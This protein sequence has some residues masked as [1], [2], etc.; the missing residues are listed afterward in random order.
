MHRSDVILRNFRSPYFVL[1]FT[2]EN[3]KSHMGK[4]KVTGTNSCHR[5]KHV[6]RRNYSHQIECNV[7]SFRYYAS[8]S[9]AISSYF[10]E[11]D[12]YLLVDLYHCNRFKSWY[13]VPNKTTHIS[14]LLELFRLLAVTFHNSTTQEHMTLL[15]DPCFPTPA[16]L[17]T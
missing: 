17:F 4:S 11:T 9:E 2:E 3:I 1:S 12:K 13:T 5:Q 14:Y 6:K 8:E 10:F 16:P 7:T 15:T